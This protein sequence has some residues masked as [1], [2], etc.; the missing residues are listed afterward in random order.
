MFFHIINNSLRKICIFTGDCSFSLITSNHMQYALKQKDTMDINNKVQCIVKNRS[1]CNYTTS[2]A[3]GQ[4]ISTSFYNSL[5]AMR[6]TKFLDLG[7][8]WLD[9][10][11]LARDIFLYNHPGLCTIDFDTIM[12]LHASQPFTAYDITQLIH[13]ENIVSRRVTYRSVASRAGT[14]KQTFQKK[15]SKYE[16][17]GIIETHVMIKSGGRK[18]LYVLT[19][20]AN[21]E[22]Q[23]IY[24]YM[25]CVMKLKIQDLPPQIRKNKTHIRKVLKQNLYYSAFKEEEDIELRMK[26]KKQVPTMKELRPKMIDD[27]KK[28]FMD[29]INEPK[30]FKL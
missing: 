29:M 28:K 12:Q 22:V 25:L 3:F 14:S 16:K 4:R 13:T 9:F 23:R 11:P 8:F 5:R 24:K 6:Q 15:I 7:F 20:S 26:G 10:L 18:K 30:E 27:V 17:L 19:K 2:K 21:S 1:H